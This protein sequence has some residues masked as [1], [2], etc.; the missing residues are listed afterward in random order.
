M[1]LKTRFGMAMVNIYTINF[2]DIIK[3]ITHLLCSLSTMVSDDGTQFYDVE[4]TR[5]AE[6]ST[7]VFLD[8]VAREYKAGISRLLMDLGAIT[9]RIFV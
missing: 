7:R 4:R 1:S 3:L 6:R 9:I 5:L 2:K 8:Y